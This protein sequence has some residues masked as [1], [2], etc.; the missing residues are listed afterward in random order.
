M[1]PPVVVNDAGGKNELYL[2]R[3]L[4][5]ANGYLLSCQMENSGQNHLILN[6]LERLDTRQ[7]YHMLE[8]KEG[9]RRL[10][11]DKIRCQGFVCFIP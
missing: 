9:L 6:A 3:G 5:K 10:H 8:Y 1:V 7:N 4:G 2:L 11:D